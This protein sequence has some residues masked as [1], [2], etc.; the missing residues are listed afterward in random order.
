LKKLLTSEQSA[1]LEQFIKADKDTVKKQADAHAKDAGGKKT[2]EAKPSK[3]QGSKK[4]GDG[5]S[6]DKTEKG[7]KKP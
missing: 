4:A 1:K 6:H 2:G 7:A 3:E 5:H